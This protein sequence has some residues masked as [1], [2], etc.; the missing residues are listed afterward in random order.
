MESTNKYKERIYKIVE[1]CVFR[2][3]KELYGGLSNMASNYPIRLNG[4]NILTSEALYQACRF[5]H[6]PEVQKKIFGEKSPMSAKMVSKPFRNQSR[7]D[8]DNVRVDIMYWCL[9]VKLAQNFL[10][11]GQLLESTFD[12]AIVEDSSK[13]PFWGAIKDK[14]NNSTLKGINALGRLLMKLRLEYNSEQRFDLLYIEPLSIPNFLIYG[15]KITVIDERQNF[16]DG[17]QRYW[18]IKPRTEIIKKVYQNEYDSKTIEKTIV[19]AE[20]LQIFE[21]PKTEKLKTSKSR[22]T[23][24]KEKKPEML[25]LFDKLP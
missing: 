5:P 15:E 7:E 24:K 9:K 12:K 22:K 21:K 25:S 3:T 18:G 14:D 10:T 4:I 17:L 16:I 6:I 19:L 23:G 13:D 8:W 2:K 20:P 1:S 11:F